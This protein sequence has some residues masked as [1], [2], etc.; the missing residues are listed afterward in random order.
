[1][2][3][4]IFG[5][6]N[7][8]VAVYVEKTMAA[9]ITSQLTDKETRRKESMRIARVTRQLLKKFCAAYRLSAEMGSGT[10][11][12]TETKQFLRESHDDDLNDEMYLTKEVYMLAIQDPDVQ[13]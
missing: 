6:F 10:A 3:F 13:K 9:A 2:I 5:L 8:I 4:V 7:L 1:M 12:P 11:T